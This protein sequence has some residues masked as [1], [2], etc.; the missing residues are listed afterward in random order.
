L[1]RFLIGVFLLPIFSALAVRARLVV[2]NPGPA[3]VFPVIDPFAVEAQMLVF[4]ARHFCSF[5]VNFFISSDFS[6]ENVRSSLS[7]IS[8]LLWYLCMIHGVFHGIPKKSLCT[9]MKNMG[10]LV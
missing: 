9:S 6:R 10:C 7:L 8:F 2:L 3:F 1:S 4:V 5:R